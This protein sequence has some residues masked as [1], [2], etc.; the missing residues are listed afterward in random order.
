MTSTNSSTLTALPA[1]SLLVQHESE[2]AIIA[3]EPP[4][5]VL[6]LIQSAN[7]SRLAR[8]PARILQNK[9]KKIEDDPSSC[10]VYTTQE[11]Q[12]RKQ[13][14][15]DTLED[16]L[17]HELGAK[18]KIFC[19]ELIHRYLLTPG[20]K[21]YQ[22]YVKALWLKERVDI[23]LGQILLFL[24]CIGSELNGLKLSCEVEER[25]FSN[26]FA[27][28]IT[29]ALDE[30]DI[31]QARFADDK[32]PRFNP[33]TLEV[34]CSLEQ[35]E[36]A[37]Y[38]AKNAL[39]QFVSKAKTAPHLACVTRLIQIILCGK[40]D[41]TKEL[42][43]DPIC[44]LL[45]E[46][47][48][49]QGIV[50]LPMHLNNGHSAVAVN[51]CR[52]SC[53]LLESDIAEGLNH[54]LALHM[55]NLLDGSIRQRKDAQGLFHFEGVLNVNFSVWQSHQNRD[56]EDECLD[57]D[58]NVGSIARVELVP[59]NQAA[60]PN[61]SN[62]DD[63]SGDQS[64][65]AMRNLRVHWA[66][67]RLIR[68]NLVSLV[69]DPQFVPHQFAHPT[70]G[71]CL[72]R[73]VDEIASSFQRMIPAG[74]TQI[75]F[76]R[77]LRSEALS[78][79]KAIQ[80]ECQSKLKMAD[81]ACKGL[82]GD[83]QVAF[84]DFVCRLIDILT[85]STSP[86][87]FKKLL[88]RLTI[89]M[90]FPEA[91]LTLLHTVLNESSEQLKKLALTR[92]NYRDNYQTALKSA[93]P[94]HL[95]LQK[96]FEGEHEP[97]IDRKTG[98]IVVTFARFRFAKQL[99]DSDY[100]WLIDFAATP[101]EEAYADHVMAR[102]LCGERAVLSADFQ[103]RSFTIRETIDG[104]V[105][106]KKFYIPLVN[107]H[108]YN[109]HLFD[110]NVPIEGEFEAELFLTALNELVGM[111]VL[112]PIVRNPYRIAVGAAKYTSKFVTDTDR[113]KPFYL[114]QIL[115]I[116]MCY[117]AENSEAV[118]KVRATSFAR[119]CNKHLT[120]ERLISMFQ[121]IKPEGIPGDTVERLIDYL[122]CVPSG[123]Q[124]VVLMKLLELGSFISQNTSLICN[125]VFKD[126]TQRFSATN[127][128]ANVDSFYFG[129]L[130]EF[131]Y[132]FTVT[133]PECDAFSFQGNFLVRV[134]K[135]SVKFA[136]KAQREQFLD[137]VNLNA[138]QWAVKID[139]PSMTETSHAGNGQNPRVSFSRLALSVSLPIPILDFL[140]GEINPALVAR[141]IDRTVAIEP[142]GLQ[143]TSVISELSAC[144]ANED[145]DAH[146]CLASAQSK[147]VAA[148]RIMHKM[149]V[150]QAIEQKRA[151]R[152]NGWVFLQ[153]A[154]RGG[155]QQLLE[156]LKTLRKKY[157]EDE[158]GKYLLAHFN[159][160]GLKLKDF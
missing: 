135:P 65:I 93:G 91:S 27:E 17:D 150:L 154:I 21:T 155:R 105:I 1:N 142:L 117:L 52:S 5:F 47:M 104:S 69:I 9:I 13:A 102:L 140:I 66:S 57:K 19:R 94:K 157:I 67:P 71:R 137:P 146:A 81:A 31:F 134:Q 116:Y 144:V 138:A 103:P 15:L 156:V 120:M 33:A 160:I 30:H 78:Y 60:L 41:Q 35:L 101:A 12:Q 152:G 139:I 63:G 29:V 148:I 85:S 38:I 43:M 124:D 141:E 53:G 87:E 24:T 158:Q 114:I 54:F 73:F 36:Y 92:A 59:A 96:A 55:P 98:A 14:I 145:L 44:F 58:R 95:L 68:E 72:N 32:R 83:E 61:S 39:A 56:P 11:F 79:Q 111:I 62:D 159:E 123:I 121:A 110:G 132:H 50:I 46:T 153:S 22:S 16:D 45:R 48:G 42:P 20:Y 28:S 129:A 88:R 86:H 113:E 8:Q 34:E 37:T 136:N 107:G 119:L 7:A 97:E 6:S 108:S 64:G 100:Q 122:A 70:T 151:P 49:T 18:D 51:G 99:F 2:A 149:V 89:R 133:P 84:R 118:Q 127:E 115:D 82:K 23:N 147:F 80:S 3:S 75:K 126:M 26:N 77:L 128:S 4:E 76:D 10:E 74:T 112:D 109:Q 90:E 40:E 130:E 131:H 25:L 143:L 125:P 106:A